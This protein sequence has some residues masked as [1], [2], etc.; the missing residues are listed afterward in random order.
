MDEFVCERNDI[1]VQQMKDIQS[2]CEDVWIKIDLFGSKPLLIGTY[3]KPHE[4]ELG[5]FFK[6]TVQSLQT[7]LQYLGRRGLQLTQDGLGP[8]V[9]VP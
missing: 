7:H 2:D 4:H 3:Y 5:G 6:I 9:P 8:Y 1:V